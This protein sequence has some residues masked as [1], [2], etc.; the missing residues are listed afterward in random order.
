MDI[1]LSARA[2]SSSS[3]LVSEPAT[4]S[5]VAAAHFRREMEHHQSTADL[6]SQTL[7]LLHDDC[8]GHRF[9]RPRTSKAALASIVERPERIRAGVLGVSAAFVRMGRRYA[10]ELFFPHPD[11]DPQHLP[12]PFR[13]RKTARAMPVNSPA[14]TNV[15]GTQ[16]MDELAVMC[17][18]AESRLALSGRELVRPNKREGDDDSAPFHEGDLYLCS[19]SLNAFQGALGGVCDGVD[20]VFS[21]SSRTSRVF[22]CIRPPGHHCSPEFPSGFCWINNVHVGISYAAMT[23]GLTH[24]AILDFDLHHGDGSQEIAWQQNNK[25]LAA[26]RNVAS[27]K[28]AAIGYFSLHDINSYP[29]EFGDMDKVRNASVC[30][31]KAHG[32]SIWNIHLEPWKTTAEFWDHYR[33]KYS[34]LIEKARAFLRFHTKRLERASSSSSSPSHPPKA[35][36]F[37]SAGFDASEWEGSGMQRHKV[38]VPTDFYAKFTADVVRMSEEEGLGVDGRV[39]S[40][41]EGGYSDRALTSGVFSH[42]AGLGDVVQKNR[43]AAVA[44]QWQSRLGSEMMAVPQND[45]DHD[46]IDSDGA[47]V[48]YDP[49]E[50]GVSRGWWQSTDLDELEAVAKLS[51]EATATTN[52]QE[53]AKTGGGAT[54]SAPTRSS[55]AKAVTNRKSIDSGVKVSP[56][57]NSETSLPLPVPDVDWATSAYEL[58]KVLI[59]DNRPTRSFRSV[60]LNAEASRVRRERQKVAL[61]SSTTHTENAAAEEVV[62]STPKTTAAAAADETKKMQLRVRRPAAAATQPSTP[63][64]APDSAA[65]RRVAVAG[66]SPSK[67]AVFDERNNRTESTSSGGGGGSGTPMTSKSTG[68]SVKSTPIAR[69]STTT[70]PRSTPRARSSPAKSAK[71]RPLPVPMANNNNNNNNNV[72]SILKEDREQQHHDMDTI[73]AGLD[74]LSIKLKVPSSEEN[75]ARENG[76]EIQEEEQQQQKQKKEEKEKRKKVRPASTSKQTVSSGK[77]EE[78]EGPRTGG[79]HDAEQKK[80][81]TPKGNNDEQPPD[82]Y[83]SAFGPEVQATPTAGPPSVPSTDDMNPN[84]SPPDHQEPQPVMATAT[85]VDEHAAANTHPSLLPAPLPNAPSTDQELLSSEALLPAADQYHQHTFSPAA[86]SSSQTRQGFS[87]FTSSSPIPFAGKS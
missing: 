63:R 10:G 30:I 44:P 84:S 41:M 59:P 81:D 68:V 46:T 29:C 23:H 15:H 51:S 20:A 82:T 61:S 13:I 57:G 79:L 19:E 80:G 1:N 33:S 25:A 56:G 42:L 74:K 18:A 17:D 70:A 37:I 87:A 14:V 55:S 32:Q 5:S 50:S 78:K 45:D 60:D 11:L 40:V 16:W 24:A 38:N 62:T 77:P 49:E 35:A 36:I 73:S 67:H 71:Q 34:V 3:A 66:R 7:V 12:V 65:S 6:D 26:H 2:H 72:P 85:V 52:S 48:E 31:E 27:Y 47:A 83:R 28:K 69:K 4:A 75:A 9:S 39:I 76:K 43:A 53:K 58:C 8:Y 22:V 21:P 54:Y 86:V 64:K